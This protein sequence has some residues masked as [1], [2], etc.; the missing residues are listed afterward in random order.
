VKFGEGKREIKA[1]RWALEFF[2][3]FVVG[4]KDNE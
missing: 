3:S 1:K 4:K 2:F